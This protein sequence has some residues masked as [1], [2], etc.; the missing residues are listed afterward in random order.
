[1]A[2]RLPRIVSDRRRLILRRDFTVDVDQ[3]G[4]IVDLLLLQLDVFYEFLSGF[5]IIKVFMRREK[6]NT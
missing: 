2:A 3:V 4:E 5:A 6:F 1:V